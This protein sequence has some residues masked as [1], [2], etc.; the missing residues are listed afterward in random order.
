MNATSSVKHQAYHHIFGKVMRGE[1]KPGERLSNRKIAREVGSSFI[2]VREAI[3]QLTSEGL[4][5]HRP[6][7]GA[8]VAQLSRKELADLY[9]LREA[10]ECHAA[11]KV[12]AAINEKRDKLTDMV[13]ACTALRKVHAEACSGRSDAVQLTAQQNERWVI[14]DATFHLSL[15]RAAGNQKAIKTVNSL[16]IM[17]NI[18]GRRHSRRSLETLDQTCLDHEIILESLL[19]GDAAAAAEAMAR[20]IQRGCRSALQTFDQRAASG[21]SDGNDLAV[22]L[23]GQIIEME[24]PADVPE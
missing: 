6:Q 22:G 8:F 9:D 4:V 1:L 14:D 3:S 11:V 13:A 24:R 15:L 18:F 10:L 21:T 19:A 7:Q 12:A 23:H 17:A 5:E 2:P 20:H 16:R